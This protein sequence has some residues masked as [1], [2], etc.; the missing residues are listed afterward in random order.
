MDMLTKNE[1]DIDD[2]NDILLV[3]TK[4]QIAG[5]IDVS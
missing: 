1:D 3:L 5:K 2:V 4:L